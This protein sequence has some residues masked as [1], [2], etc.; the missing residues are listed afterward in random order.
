M[1][2]ADDFYS[3]LR[4]GVKDL[5]SDDGV[6]SCVVTVTR[7]TSANQSPS[8]DWVASTQTSDVYSMDAVVVG[9]EQEYVDGDLVKADDLQIIAPPYATL[10]G[11]EQLFEPK[12]TDEYTIDGV[13][14]VCN[15]IERIP[16]SGTATAFFIF[17]KS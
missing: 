1:T 10:N 5:I 15:K 14:H 2:A 13:V 7:I 17:V 4:A 11:T 3:S 6:K 12:S 9:V 16:A 8:A